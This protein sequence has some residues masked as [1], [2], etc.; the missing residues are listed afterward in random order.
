[1]PPTA[2]LTGAVKE[3]SRWHV[4]Y[5][6]GIAVVFR[7]NG[8]TGVEEQGAQISAANLGDGE[9]R[10]RKVTKTDGSDQAITETKPKT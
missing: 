8:R 9:G 7:A 6:D 4:V 1:M 3:S 10:D 2:P 5:D